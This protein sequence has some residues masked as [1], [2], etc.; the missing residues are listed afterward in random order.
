MKK[1]ENKRVFNCYPQLAPVVMNYLKGYLKLLALGA[2]ALGLGGVQAQ[3]AQHTQEAHTQAGSTQAAPSQGEWTALSEHDRL[4]AQIWGLEKEEMQRA[5]V[6]LQGP[7][8]AFSVENLLPIEALGI[9]ARTDAERRKYAEAFA[10]AFHQDVQ[11]SLAWQREFSA[12]MQRLYPGEPVIDWSGQAPV[13]AHPGAAQI[14]HLP[15]SMLADDAPATP[16]P[17]ASGDAR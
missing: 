12:A 2:I 13:R 8:K 4:L 5:K 16:V 10:R 15:H 1:Q 11:R 7:R 14:L 17:A 6:L 3:T 9:H